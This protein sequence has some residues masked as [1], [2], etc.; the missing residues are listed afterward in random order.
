MM[1]ALKGIIQRSVVRKCINQRVGSALSSTSAGSIFSSHRTPAKN[2]KKYGPLIANIYKPS[3]VQSKLKIIISSEI[4]FALE[5][6]L[7]LVAF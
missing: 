5:I 4:T 2:T 7:A 3:F 6:D 1:N